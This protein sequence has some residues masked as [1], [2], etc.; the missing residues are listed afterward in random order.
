MKYWEFKECGREDNGL[1]SKEL[2]ICPAYPNHG[3]NC[4]RIAGTLCGG[5]VQDFFA[6]K[7]VNCM[8][9]DFYKSP[10]YDKV[11]KS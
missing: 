2:G 11:N 9:C 4:A 3:T 10:H 1:K 6:M 5:N 7:V 8:Q